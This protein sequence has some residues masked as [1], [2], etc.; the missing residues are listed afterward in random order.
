MRVNLPGG[1]R[2]FIADHSVR[3]RVD[4][5]A[6]KA[7]AGPLR[8]EAERIL[9]EECFE[10]CI[11]DEKF[12]TPLP[13]PVR[14]SGIGNAAELKDADFPRGN[15]N[16]RL[17][18]KPVRFDFA[19]FAHERSALPIQHRSG[20][21]PEQRFLRL[22]GGRQLRFLRILRVGG[23]QRDAPACAAG[24]HAVPV[25]LFRDLAQQFGAG[26]R[27]RLIGDDQSSALQLLE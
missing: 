18:P 22:S 23:D 11:G 1:Q 25:D 2:D 6:V 8:L 21:G 17:L 19:A 14:A 7:S 4:L 15:R 13:L 10:F 12:H 20:N 24:T 27:F 16:L 9:P 5:V 26:R 3:R